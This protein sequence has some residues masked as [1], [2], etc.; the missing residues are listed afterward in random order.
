MGEAKRRAAIA[1]MV[2]EMRKASG[3]MLDTHVVETSAISTLFD[4]ARAGDVTAKRLVKVVSS[5]I[6]ELK[7]KA[8]RCIMCGATVTEAPGAV[9]C[10]WP[11]IAD[12]DDY[13]SAII[14]D[15]CVEEGEIASR[16]AEKARSQFAPGGRVVSSASDA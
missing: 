15:A 2:V 8:G 9:G 12:P 7:K 3:G 4:Q 6:L 1:D 16:F 10:V 5:V 11:R 13:L 14:C